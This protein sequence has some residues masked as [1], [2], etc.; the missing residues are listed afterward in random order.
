MDDLP[1]LDGDD[2]TPNGCTTCVAFPLPAA[3]RGKAAGVE[4]GNDP[5]E[6]SRLA[7]V[8]WGSGPRVPVP[9]AIPPMGK[10]PVRE[11]S[12][13][14]TDH[15]RPRRSGKIRVCP[16]RSEVARHL[17][18]E[19]LAF[20]RAFRDRTVSDEPWFGRRTFAEREAHEEGMDREWHIVGDSESGIPD[21]FV[22]GIPGRKD[23]L[24]G[25]FL[26]FDRAGLW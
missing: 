19:A 20:E 6:G 15:R 2:V 21:A 8:G 13:P 3:R 17:H 14:P 26:R 16:V 10:Q 23:L 24:V 9:K 25:L 4:L 5:L 11:T 18:R 1:D 22:S 12:S 7:A